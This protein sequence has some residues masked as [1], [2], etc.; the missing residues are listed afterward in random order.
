MMHRRLN[1]LLLA[2]AAM[3]LVAVLGACGGRD[4]EPTPFPTPTPLAAV[5]PAA[6]DASVTA[7]AEAKP[8]STPEST[9]AAAAESASQPESPFSPMPTP[10]LVPTPTSLAEGVTADAGFS[11]V[12]GQV[13]DRDTG[14]PIVAMDIRL[15]EVYCPEDVKPE[16]K[17]TRCFWA[18]DDARSPYTQTTADGSFKFLNVEPRDF[19]LLLGSALGSYS[20][21]E[22]ADGKANIYTAPEGE[23]LNIGTV[24]LKKP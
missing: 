15:A 21:S 20:L 19:A 23:V 17:V 11:S 12:V 8:E 5:Q 13:L 24:E 6:E 10:T 18:I 16:E 3:L 2:M 14:Q 4:E 7:A 9:P 22:R 1:H